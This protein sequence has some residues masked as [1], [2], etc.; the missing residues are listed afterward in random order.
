MLGV[1]TD[2][3]LGAATGVAGVAAAAAPIGATAGIILGS[4]AQGAF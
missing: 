4:F 2:L 1:T 3:V